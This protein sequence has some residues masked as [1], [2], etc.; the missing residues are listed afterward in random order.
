MHPRQPL[1]QPCPSALATW[2]QSSPFAHTP[3]RHVPGPPEP[4]VLERC[5]PSH[6][7][8]SHLLF[9]SLTCLV[10]CGQTLV[11]LVGMW[12][13]PAQAVA[14]WRREVQSP[15]AGPPQGPQ[16]ALHHLESFP[17]LLP[18]A[19]AQL[20]SPPGFQPGGSTNEGGREEVRREGG[21]GSH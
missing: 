20:A 15:Q 16:S 2:D 12:W 7:T 9:S 4:G 8:A 5:P 21:G 19:S 6:C 10:I 11:A 18:A 14:G 17:D 3:P 1:F 13:W